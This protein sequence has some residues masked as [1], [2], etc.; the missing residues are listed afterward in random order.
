MLRRWKPLPEQADYDWLKRAVLGLVWRR[1]VVCGHLLSE[2]HQMSLWHRERVIYP[3]CAECLLCRGLGQRLGQPQE[4][5][6]P[7]GLVRRAA[8]RVLEGVY[9]RVVDISRV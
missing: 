3:V 6:L 7:A 2:R 1:C 8:P 9:R 5:Y 4:W